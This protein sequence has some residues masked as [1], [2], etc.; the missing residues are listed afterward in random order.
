MHAAT[1]RPLALASSAVLLLTVLGAC[2]S[3]AA[4]ARPGDVAEDAVSAAVSEA[5]GAASSAEARDLPIDETRSTEGCVT[6]SDCDDEV[7]CTVDT[8]EE[9]TGLCR[10]TPDD[11][12]CGSSGVETC[13]PA[14][15]C[16]AECIF[17]ADCDDGGFCNGA[18]SCEAGRCVEGS[19]VNCDDDISCTVAVCDEEDDQCRRFARDELCEATE[20]CSAAAGCIP[21]CT[22]DADCDDGLFCNGTE[23][24]DT[25]RCVSSEAVGCDDEVSCTIDVCDEATD[26][27]RHVLDDGLCSSQ[28]TCHALDGCIPECTGDA[29]CDDG[30]FCNGA[31]S[32]QDGSCVA[33]TDPAD[34]GL[35]CTIGFCSEATQSIQQRPNHSACDADLQWC[36]GIEQCDLTQGCVAAPVEPVGSNDFG[37]EAYRSTES[38]SACAHSF[39]VD[40]SSTG[41]RLNTVRGNTDDDYVVVE[42]G[43]PGFTLYGVTQQTVYAS[44]NGFIQFDE[45]SGSLRRFANRCGNTSGLSGSNPAML[46]MHDDLRFPNSA[47]FYHQHFDTC[48]RPHDID[49][50]IGCNIIQWDR[51]YHYAGSSSANWKMQAVLYNNGEDLAFVY[52]GDTREQGLGATVGI[53]DRADSTAT[54][55]LETS[56]NVRN[57]IPNNST[58]CFYT[59]SQNICN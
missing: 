57:A 1:P 16:I 18:E 36:N 26:S 27:C 29:D 47:S 15:G 8:C 35:A 14:S 3:K 59:R 25:G 31:E 23:S 19:P 7:G 38:P 5:G 43:G 11:S 40:I 53:R 20:T 42:L 39:F 6:D 22:V 28:E 13:S 37:H 34:D 12:L 9:A 55:L 45:E 32:C 21:E 30:V 58:L 17:D 54:D 56:C 24:C 10:H 4:S 51:V 48:P 41:T 49:S 50:S 33:G 46:V 52:T 2:G 44:T